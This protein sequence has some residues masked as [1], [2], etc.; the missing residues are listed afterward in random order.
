[1]LT[2]H[3]AAAVTANHAQLKQ[4]K[5]QLNKEEKLMIYAGFWK[6]AVALILDMLIVSIPT[7]LIFGPMLAFETLGLGEVNPN[8][9]SPTQAGILG[10][11]IFSWQVVS[12]IVTWLYFAFLESGKKQST[13]G[14][15]LLGIKV[16]GATGERISF[17]RATGRFFAK[18]ISYLIANIGFI[19]AGF[20]GR[21]RALH[22]MIAETYVVKKEYQEGQSLPET[23]SHKLWLFI[24]CIVWLLFIVGT[25][26]LSSQLS[27]TPT[28]Q[29][30]ANAAAFMKNLTQQ[31]SVSNEPIRT[32]GVTYFYT[33]EGY[34]AVVTDP[35]SNNKFTLFLQKGANNACCQAFP[36]GDC[37][38][39]GIEACK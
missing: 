19:M 12:F 38:D 35:V 31:A 15:R 32:E 36:F 18:T 2:K 25:S 11:T 16:V 21:K 9:I 29:A 26:L 5:V 37:K 39:T 1:M 8:N 33:P 17:A 4:N 27:R 24:V 10:A 13:W 14:K 3:V 6:R 20:T 28:Q 30:A 34:R 22:D 7:M 23:P